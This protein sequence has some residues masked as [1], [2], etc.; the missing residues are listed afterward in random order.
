GTDS[1]YRIAYKDLQ[2]ALAAPVE[3]IQNFDHDYTFVGN[4]GPV[5]YFKTDLEAPRGRLIAIDTRKPEKEHWKEIVPQAKENLRDVTLVGNRFVAD[6]LKDA[7]SQVKV[8]ALDGQPVREVELPG[9]GTA[10]GFTGKRRDTE[11][12]YTFSSFTT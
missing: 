7:H 10:G 3:L 11:T 2:E 9:L 5:F 1:R 4:D 12:L 8:F 6:Y